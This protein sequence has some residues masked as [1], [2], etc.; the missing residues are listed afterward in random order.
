MTL[1]ENCC[2]TYLFIKDLLKEEDGWI[3]GLIGWLLLMK[4]TLLLLCVCK[5]EH[6]DFKRD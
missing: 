1:P 2:S 6:Q 5:P 3:D 4:M